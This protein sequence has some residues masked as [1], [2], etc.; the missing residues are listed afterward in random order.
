MYVGSMLKSCWKYVERLLRSHHIHCFQRLTECIMVAMMSMLMM[1]MSK[2]VM[3]MMLLMM[4]RMMMSMS[5]LIMSDYGV[6]DDGSDDDDE[7]YHFDYHIIYAH[8]TFLRLSRSSTNSECDQISAPTIYLVSESENCTV[9][10]IIILCYTIYIRKPTQPGNNQSI[11]PSVHP[12]IH[13]CIY[14]H[15]EKCIHP[16]IYSSNH[17]FILS[18]VIFVIVIFINLTFVTIYIFAL[19]SHTIS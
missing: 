12:S 4:I 9:V 16:T 8:Y 18:F 5:M 19:S 6:D 15:I 3:M 7:L 1:M 13:P 2:L 14:P 10:T 17:P 11:Y